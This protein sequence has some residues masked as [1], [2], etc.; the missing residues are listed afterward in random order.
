M[1]LITHRDIMSAQFSKLATLDS[2]S[3]R[4]MQA[5]MKI[6]DVMSEDVWTVMPDVPLA[7]AAQMLA[8]H[9]FGCLPV[10]DDTYRL[11]GILTE[12]DFVTYARDVL[13]AQEQENG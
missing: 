12:A 1:G 9:K 13:L 10:V 11:V 7:K 5:G 4:V 6:A 8:D 3:R 2:D